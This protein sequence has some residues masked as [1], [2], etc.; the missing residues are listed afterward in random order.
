MYFCW[1][2]M[3]IKTGWGK[4]FWYEEGTWETSVTMNIKNKSPCYEWLWEIA[5]HMERIAYVW[6]SAASIN[7]PPLYIAIL[8]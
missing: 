2:D 1:A 6:I 4:F 5:M 3:G 8:S 7:Y